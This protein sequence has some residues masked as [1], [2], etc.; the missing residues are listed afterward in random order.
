MQ[1]FVAMRFNFAFCFELFTF[2]IYLTSAPLG[3]TR[4]PSGHFVLQIFSIVYNMY[5]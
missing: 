3:K 4:W 1:S 5:I 2:C